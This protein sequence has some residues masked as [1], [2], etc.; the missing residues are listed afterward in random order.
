MIYR[1]GNFNYNIDTLPD[2]CPFC[3]NGIKPEVIFGIT[4][5]KNDED[6]L[7]IFLNCPKGECNESFI[8]YYYRSGNSDYDLENVSEGNILKRKF[9]KTIATISKSFTKIYNQSEFAEKKKLY[10][11]CGVGYR[12]ALE[13]LIK[14]YAI[15]K[16]PT[17]KNAIEN[18][19]LGQCIAEHVTDDRIKIVSKRAVWLGNDE[20]HYV[21]KW[22][23]KTLLDLKKLIDLTLHWIEAEI[24]TSSFEQSMPD[25]SKIK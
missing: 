14:D 1:F 6:Y 10:E 4:V 22:E 9:S 18:K 7:H 20:T 5:Q 21:K 19:L 25:N 15:H 24:L 12:K 16:N 13:F 17:Q 11:I 8:A 23:G 3:H 2:F